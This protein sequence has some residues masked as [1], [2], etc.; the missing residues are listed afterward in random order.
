MQVCE[1][2]DPGAGLTMAAWA[3]D[4]GREDVGEGRASSFLLVIRPF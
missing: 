4:A 3:G 1:V 2:L